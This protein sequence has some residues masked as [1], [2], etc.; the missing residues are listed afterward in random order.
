MFLD[1]CLPKIKKM[2]F[3]CDKYYTVTDESVLPKII[4]IKLKGIQPDKRKT[5]GSI[6]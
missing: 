4:L 3:S 6:Y 2:L 5:Q 1:S